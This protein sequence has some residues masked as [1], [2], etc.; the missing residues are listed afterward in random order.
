MLGDISPD[1]FIPIAEQ[2]GLFGTI[3]RWVVSQAFRE[4]ADL[5]AMFN[6][7]IQVSINLSSAELN[8]LKL[9]QFI[10]QQART[11]QVPPQ[12]IDFEITE[13]F[14]ADSQSFPLL[15]ELSRLG[16][17][18]TIDDFGSGYTSITQLGSNT[19]YKR[20]SLIASF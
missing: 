12:W 7:P 13:T 2:T 14:A 8:S 6:E 10:H 11:Y 1:E 19:Q 18:L 16:Y 17:G 3:D 20:L 5:Q 4:F 9:A 15:H